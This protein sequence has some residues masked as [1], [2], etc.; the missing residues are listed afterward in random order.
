LVCWI[1]PE[2]KNRSWLQ[3]FQLKNIDK[4]KESTAGFA[5][6]LLCCHQFVIILKEH[7]EKEQMRIEAFSK[8]FMQWSAKM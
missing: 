2:T 1:A 4:H 8:L 3:W 5:Q 7:A 6:R